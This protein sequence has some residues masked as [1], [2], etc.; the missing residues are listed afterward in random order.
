MFTNL[1][2]MLRQQA[3]EI[4]REGHAGWGNTMQAAADR[5]EWL[6][7]EHDRLAAW[8]R[9]IDG[10]DSPCLDEGTLRQWAY[11]AVTLQMPA[12]GD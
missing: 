5:I 11:N 8:L 12:E 7:A 1:I 2:D 4:A 6:E 10:G 3:D 9:R